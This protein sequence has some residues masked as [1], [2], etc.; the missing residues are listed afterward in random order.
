MFIVVEYLAF[1]VDASVLDSVG[2]MTG[3]L[4]V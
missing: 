4:L 3:R 1:P 2:S